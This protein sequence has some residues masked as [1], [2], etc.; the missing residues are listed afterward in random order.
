M[1]EAML[2]A[3]SSAD[4]AHV[5]NR[6]VGLVTADTIETRKQVGSFGPTPPQRL[7]AVIQVREGDRRRPREPRSRA[8]SGI[9]G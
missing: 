1:P 6:A 2:S 9:A 5:V 8:G 3:D 4:Y 7:R